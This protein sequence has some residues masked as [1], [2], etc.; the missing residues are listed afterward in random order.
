VDY[1]LHDIVGGVQEVLLD[2]LLAPPRLRR[3]VD[4]TVRTPAGEQP[5]TIGELF[6]TLSAAIWSELGL[7]AQKPRDVDS[8]R[9]NLQRAYVD[10]LIGILIPSRGAATVTGPFGGSANI[11]P[12]EDARA[13]ARY[14][15]ARLSDR[16]AAAAPATPTL[17]LE[18]RAHFAESKAKIDRALAASITISK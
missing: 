10:Q 1:P 12:P 5:Y 16:L 2:E 13:L 14:E 7:G 6:Q 4:N 9:R 8:F 15:L 3:L 18:T 17:D 11:E